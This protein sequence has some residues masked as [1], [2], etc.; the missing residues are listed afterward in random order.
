MEL[1]ILTPWSHY[2]TLDFA[3]YDKSFNC[4]VW[5]LMYVDYQKFYLNYVFAKRH[6]KITYM[7]PWMKWKQGI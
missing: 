2:Y 5:R 3:T 4:V 6:G 1:S 7:I